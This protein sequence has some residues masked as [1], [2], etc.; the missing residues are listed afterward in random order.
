MREQNQGIAKINAQLEE[1]AVRLRGHRTS[2]FTVSSSS[3][4]HSQFAMSTGGFN[5]AP[6]S[7]LQTQPTQGSAA[8]RR[9]P[10]TVPTLLNEHFCL[11]LS[12]QFYI[13][14]TISSTIGSTIGN[15]ASP[16]SEIT[17]D[18]VPYPKNEHTCSV[19]PMPMDDI[20]AIDVIIEKR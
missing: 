6:G 11:P 20:C 2:R 19:N 16:G 4:R 8:W 12:R 5:Q 18:T 14:A 13:D 1:M 17:Q 15:M 3:R 10:A 7:S 9:V